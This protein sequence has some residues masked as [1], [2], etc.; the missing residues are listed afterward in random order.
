MKQWNLRHERK[1]EESLWQALVAARKIENPG[2][3]FAAASQEDL[4]DPF[5]FDDMRKS[6]DRIMTAIHAKERI[7]VYGDYDV[8][9]TSGSAI[10]IHSMRFLGAEVSYR[11]PHRRNDGYGLHNHYVE[12]VVEKGVTVLITVDCGIS[13]PDQVELAN[14]LNL[15]V[16]IT[17]HHTVPAKLPK[18]YAILH[19][20][21]SE[22]YPFKYLAGSGVA[23]KLA[24]AL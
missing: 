3:F 18:A 21:L 10:L 2:A 8:D 9:G 24:C 4:H 1:A 17:D 5:L 20:D 13:C 22:N 14:K 7:V 11:I 16:I 12:E 6:V 15:D 19:P 23:F